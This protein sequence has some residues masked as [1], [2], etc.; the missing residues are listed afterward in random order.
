M[1]TE[2]EHTFRRRKCLE[3]KLRLCLSG[4]LRQGPEFELFHKYLSRAQKI[5]KTINF[6][7]IEVSEYNGLT[8]T[9]PLLQQSSSR[10]F[11]PNSVKVLLDEKGKNISSNVFSDTL[12][13]HRDNGINEIIFFIGGA[14]G[15]PDSVTH[16]FDETISFGKMVWPHLFVRVM[17]MEQIYRAITIIGRLPYH[18]D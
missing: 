14:E 3:M 7:S 13:S 8:W 10:G 4:R 16:C 18:K 1:A 9:R 17:L 15:V 6:S 5:G 2:P 11:S 12:R